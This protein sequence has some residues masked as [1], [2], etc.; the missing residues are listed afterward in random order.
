[1]SHGTLLTYDAREVGAFVGI[2]DVAVEDRREEEEA[3]MRGMDLVDWFLAI[4]ACLA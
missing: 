4:D 3:P 2:G 1:V